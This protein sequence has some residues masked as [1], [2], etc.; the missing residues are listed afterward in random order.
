[1]I[2]GGIVFVPGRPCE[3][4]TYVRAI[5]HYTYLWVVRVY[6]SIFIRS[7]ISRQMCYAEEARGGIKSMNKR[8]ENPFNSPFEIDRLPDGCK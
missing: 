5:L 1:M 7:K 2:G 4:D 8:W 6:L 3:Y